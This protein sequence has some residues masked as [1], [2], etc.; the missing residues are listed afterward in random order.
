M[1]KDLLKN[2]LF[3]GGLVFFVLF[4]CGGLL[5]LSHVKRTTERELA[6]SR[7]L[8]KQLQASQQQTEKEPAVEN[9]QGGHTHADGTWHAEPHTQTPQTQVA[10]HTEPVT[11]TDT[12]ASNFYVYGGTKTAADLQKEID[13][14]W[15]RH[16]NFPT[17]PSSPDGSIPRFP[18]SPGFNPNEYVSREEYEKAFE[19]FKP[20]SNE[21]S[22]MLDDALRSIHGGGATQ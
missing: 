8:L 9:A 18:R 11:D 4:V 20:A 15:Q 14:F 1:F 10:T 2:R 7:E 3:V 16:P 17:V 21:L 12:D 13:D 19:I 6:R 5:Y 22:Q